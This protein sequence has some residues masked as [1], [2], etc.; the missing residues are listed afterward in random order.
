[1]SIVGK[2]STLFNRLLG[3]VQGSI[4]GPILYAIFVAPLFQIENL[5]GFADDMFILREG[6]DLTTLM[7]DLER[8]LEK[9]SKWY[10]Q[11]GLLL[12]HSKPYGNLS[13]L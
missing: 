4:L 3:T 12:N 1:V 6:C 5:E 13:I 8:S 2:K 9:I 7:N 10:S 11:S